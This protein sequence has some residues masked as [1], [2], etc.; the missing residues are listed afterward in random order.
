MQ[1]ER[2]QERLVSADSW[3]ETAMQMHVFQPGESERSKA[4]RYCEAVAS[5]MG[6]ACLTLQADA[7]ARRLRHLAKSEPI[8]KAFSAQ[9]RDRS[10]KFG[11][12]PQPEAAVMCD[13][14]GGVN[15]LRFPCSA[16]MYAGDW[17]VD[18][19]AVRGYVAALAAMHD[20]LTVRSMLA[21]C[22]GDEKDRDMVEA[23][24]R[25]FK[26]RLLSLRVP[27]S[28]A[29]AASFLAQQQDML[30]HQLVL[31]LQRCLEM[32][33]ADNDAVAVA[34][35]RRSLAM[36]T[37]TSEDAETEQ[38]LW[39][40]LPSYPQHCSARALGPC[41]TLMERSIWERVAGLVAMLGLKQRKT[42]L[43]Q[44]QIVELM[45]QSRMRN[46]YSLCDRRN[47]L[48]FYQIMAIN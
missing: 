32:F 28:T 21:A 30:S 14:T 3:I 10:M 2:V 20:V 46:R 35:V 26:D 22:A 24:V 17:S 12:R 19:K 36:T 34:V 16:E 27:L 47:L 48:L 40:G 9:P 25:R 43:S 41:V 7:V 11:L 8:S 4:R 42:L 18:A 44:W 33:L 15:L 38:L 13:E 5:E 29:D 31:S 39:R 23:D 45:V 1:R 37:G 6:L